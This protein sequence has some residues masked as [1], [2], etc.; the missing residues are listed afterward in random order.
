MRI[1]ETQQQ[2]A[3]L[4][5]EEKQHPGSLLAIAGQIQTLL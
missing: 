1:S 2:M 5:E 3:S 4:I